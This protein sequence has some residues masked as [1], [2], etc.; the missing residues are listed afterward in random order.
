MCTKISNQI[1]YLYNSLWIGS[2]ASD[3]RKNFTM[4]L[5]SVQKAKYW[6]F[7]HNCVCRAGRSY[8]RLISMALMWEDGH[9]RGSALEGQVSDHRRSLSEVMR[10]DMW[11]WSGLNNSQI[12]ST[13]R[14]S[15]S[16]WVGTY[17]GNTL[18]PPY[19]WLAWS[20]VS[21]WNQ[22][23]R[24]EYIWLYPMYDASQIM[25]MCASNYH[26]NHWFICCV[27]DA[28]QY[29]SMPHSVFNCTK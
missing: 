7:F 25:I 12:V 19:A 17:P 28:W 16:T 22:W 1:L 9:E 15:I 26:W 24:V 11:S 6:F 2:W 5:F 29:V 8:I 20:L 23:S 27:V 13:S 14:A 21:R 4:H 18:D 3:Q 10:Q